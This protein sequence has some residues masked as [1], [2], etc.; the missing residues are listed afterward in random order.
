[1]RLWIH[2]ADVAAHVRPGT[3]L[4]AEA[5]RRATSTYVPGTVEPMLPPAL[6]ER[7]LQPRAGRR[8]ARGHGRDRAVGAAGEARRRASTAAG[9]APTPASTTTSSTRSSPAARRPPDVVA[10]PLDLARDAAAALAEPRARIGALEVESC[11]P[12]F[13]FDPTATSSRPA[14]SPQTEAHRLIE[15][16]MILTNEQVAEL[17]ERERVPTLY[18]VH[19]QPDPQ[20]VERLV[21]QLAALDVPTPPLPERLGPRRRASSSARRAG[22]SRAEARRRGHGRAGVYIA[23]AALAEAGRLQPPQPRPRRARQPRLR[24]LHLADPPLSRPRSPTARCCRRSAR[25]RTRPDPAIGA[26]GRRALL[27]ARARGDEGRAR[28]RRRLRR[29]P[30]R[31]R[32]VRVAAGSA[33]SRARSS[34]LVGGGRVRRASAATSPTSTRA[35]C[36]RGCCAASA[37][38]ST[39][40]RRRWSGARTG[41]ADPPGRSGHGSRR[42]RSRRRGGAS[43]SIRPARQAAM[44]KGEG[45]ARPPRATSPPTAARATATSC[46]RPTSAGSSCSAPRSSRC[47]TARPSSSTPTR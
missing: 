46:S 4:D 39:R 44:A 27:G 8:A 23:R 12:E 11:E 1:M 24:S 5:Y 18:R 2:I 42:R 26:R 38:S 14:R 41:R 20:R 21:E 3:A 45:S 17:L 9:S 7:R 19:E 28:R 13:E 16:L 25:A 15:Q 29:V 43:T 35:S 10:E 47:A 36:R 34:G 6:S 31:A 33:S 32:A 22:W 40:P 30:A 37:S